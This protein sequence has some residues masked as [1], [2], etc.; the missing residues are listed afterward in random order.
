MKKVQLVEIT[1]EQ[2]QKM[3][4]IEIAEKI[5]ELKEVLKPVEKTEYLTRTEVSE[6]LKIN[7]STVHKWTKQNYL[8]AYYLGNRVYYKRSE[9][10]NTLCSV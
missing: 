2:L 9:I 10:E 6:L 5:E 8:H 3:L 4:A 7:L 1:P